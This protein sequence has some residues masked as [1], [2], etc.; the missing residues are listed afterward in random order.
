MTLNYFDEN[1]KEFY[2]KEG[3]N[4]ANYDILYRLIKKLS[5]QNQVEKYFLWSNRRE[6]KNNKSYR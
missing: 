3:E 5:E 1:K 6:F 4:M 2:Y